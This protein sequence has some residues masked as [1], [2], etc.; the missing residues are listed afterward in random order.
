M[1]NK[2][3]IF[4]E[5]NDDMYFINFLLQSL[6]GFSLPDSGNIGGFIK[7]SGMGKE[8]QDGNDI[9][10]LQSKKLGYL[11]LLFEDADYKSNSPYGF[12][13]QAERLEKLKSELNF[14]YFLFPNHKDDGNLELIFETCLSAKSSKI[15][16]CLNEYHECLTKQGLVSKTPKTYHSRW[17]M[18][19]SSLLDIK[20]PEQRNFADTEI[21]N[22][23]H[24]PYLKPLIDFLDKFFKQ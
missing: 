18:I 19:E 3:T 4:V 9:K 7:M 6:Y 21:W 10:F 12:V 8:K 20:K 14:E 24:N 23:P 1:K 2:V 11:N 5:N 16:T 22:M 13:K 15:V 17:N